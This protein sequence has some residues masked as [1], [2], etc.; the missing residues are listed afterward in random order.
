MLVSACTTQ[1]ANGGSLGVVSSL[2]LH[3]QLHIVGLKLYL[4]L[5]VKIKHATPPMTAIF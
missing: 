2:L 1:E 3:R 5:L 4:L